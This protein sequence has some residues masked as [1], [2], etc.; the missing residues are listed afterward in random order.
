MADT[1]E[2]Q[3]AP[4][5]AEPP[6]FQA[7]SKDECTMAMLCHLLALCCYV[8]IPFGNILGPLVIWLIKKDEYPLVDDQGKESLNFQITI[9]IA[10]IVC[11]PLVFVIVGIFLLV[12]LM[13]CQ[14][15]FVILAAIKA[16]NGEA[17]RYPF[18]L[19]LIK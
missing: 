4:D 19:R 7:P 12:A 10:S 16:S 13:V 15:V 2:Q 8:G 1:G 14:V 11:I 17:Y 5:A 9:S 6:E 18:T 3:P